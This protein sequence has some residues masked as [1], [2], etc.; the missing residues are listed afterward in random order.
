MK[1]FQLTVVLITISLYSASPTLA[2]TKPQ[3]KRVTEKDV[4]IDFRVRWDGKVIPGIQKVSGLR[5]TTEV[6]THRSGV[7]PSLYRRSPGITNYHPIIIERPRSSAQE[8]EQ[9][10]NKVWNLGSGLGSEVSLKDYR[11]DIVVELITEDGKVVLAYKIYRCWPSEYT[12]LTD[13]NKEDESLAMESLILEH[14]G[15]ER[16]YSI[17]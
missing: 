14:E 11:K 12:A 16:N 10:A 13:L 4:K 2:E 1:I 8:F 3:S 5:R 17:K 15:W 6:I 9:W 7:E